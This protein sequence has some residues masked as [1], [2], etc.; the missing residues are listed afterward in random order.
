[1]K[2]RD[3]GGMLQLQQ[4]VGA[5]AGVAVLLLGAGSAHAITITSAT[6]SSGT[7][8]VSGSQAAKSVN[9]TW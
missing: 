5:L 2:E 1:M 4:L 9:I 8:S 3:V 6:L 7:V